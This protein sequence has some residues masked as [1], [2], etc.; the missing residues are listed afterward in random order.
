MKKKTVTAIA[1]LATATLIYIGT[2]FTHQDPKNQQDNTLVSN[3]TAYNTAQAASNSNS[4]AAS[5]ENNNSIAVFPDY[6]IKVGKEGITPFGYIEATV[7]EVTDGDTF[8]I[9][10]KNKEYKVRML[11]VDTPESVK[12]GVKPQP[13]AKEASELTKKTLTG[14]KVKLIFEKGTTDQYERLL[15]FV[16]L[17]DG[18]FYNAFLIQKGY[19]IAVFYK[20][21]TM[22]T[23]YFY[24]LQDR[25][26]SRKAGFWSLNERDRPFIQDSKGKYIAAYKSK[27]GA[28]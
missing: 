6:L 17:Q 19:A 21:N 4:S 15:A 20:P 10:Y 3:S 7:K 18:T 1:T 16:I 22:L 23:D 26:I 12:V 25:A 9:N 27:K 14:Q 5:S 2:L 13:F 11:D 28:A 24:D 8:H